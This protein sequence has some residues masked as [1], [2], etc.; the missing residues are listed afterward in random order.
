MKIK[1]PNCEQEYEVEN[2]LSGQKVECP[3][4]FEKFIAEVKSETKQCPFCAEI[5]QIAANKCKH[6]GEFLRTVNKAKTIMCDVC[7]GLYNNGGKL[8]SSYKHQDKFEIKISGT[9]GTAF[10]GNYMVVYSNGTNESKSVEGTVPE[11]IQIGGDVLIIS[12]TMQKKEDNLNTLKVSININGECKATSD[13]YAAYG[14]ATAA[15]RK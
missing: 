8:P 3:D 15:T 9:T 10:T 1:C 5:I 14:V 2:G 4:C 7:F 12:C 13:T 6:C 11:N